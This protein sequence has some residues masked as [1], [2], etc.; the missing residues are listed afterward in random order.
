MT[1]PSRDDLKPGIT[2]GADLPVALDER[3]LLSDAPRSLV[4]VGLIWIAVLVAAI[5]LFKYAIDVLFV[6]LVLGCVMESMAVFII[7]LPALIPLMKGL[8]VDMVQ[9]GVI[10]T[11]NMMMALITPPV[12]MTLYIV[13]DIAH[14]K[15]DR[16]VKHVIPFLISM[17]VTLMLVT[18]WDGMVMLLPTLLFR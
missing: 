11:I 13:S 14:T 15:F 8:G 7:S 2:P 12:G 9:F 16:V 17:F 1:G 10:I 5:A 3:P 18:Y 6:L 4:V